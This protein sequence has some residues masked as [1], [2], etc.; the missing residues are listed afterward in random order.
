MTPSPQDAHITQAVRRAVGFATLQ[1]LRKI[2]DAEHTR[3][4]HD[5]R[6]ARQ[7]AGLFAFA[8]LIFLILLTLRMQP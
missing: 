5:A 1:R 6:R 8:A 7:L 2:A 4:R 3:E